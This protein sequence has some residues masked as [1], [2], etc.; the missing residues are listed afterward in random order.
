MRLSN[1]N[2][3]LKNKRNEQKFK[4]QIFL[5]ECETDKVAKYFSQQI[6]HSLLKRIIY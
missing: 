5:I 4:G 2:Y 1:I 6:K 3:K